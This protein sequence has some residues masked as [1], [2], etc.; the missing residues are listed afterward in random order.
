MKSKI[1]LM[2]L[3]FLFFVCSASAKIID[4]TFSYYVS[5][6][7]G[8]SDCALYTTTSGTWKMDDLSPSVKNNEVNN[9]T[10][11]S[12]NEGTYQWNVKCEDNSGNAKFLSDRNWTFTVSVPTILDVGPESRNVNA[13]NEFSVNV[14]IKGVDDLY[15]IMFN[16][17]YN[18]EVLEFV[19]IATGEFL[20][21]GDATTIAGFIN[22]SGMVSYI[23]TRVG[24][25]GGVSGD[26]VI[27]QATF[28]AIATGTDTLAYSYS[29]LRDSS[30]EEIVHSTATG[31]VEV[32][33]V[34]GKVGALAAD[35]CNVHCSALGYSSGADRFKLWVFGRCFKDEVETGKSY[36]LL[37]TCCCW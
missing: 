11:S 16:L 27:A 5:D 30:N 19:N 14:T 22:E 1:A 24:A 10:L 8:V 25:I 34:S 35:S 2:A 23:E 33:V 28:R 37:T 7:A 18:P 17:T 20:S 3:V 29:E 21:R 15:A 12:I 13:G 9:F 6:P 31:T 36:K 32:S 4:V 26:G